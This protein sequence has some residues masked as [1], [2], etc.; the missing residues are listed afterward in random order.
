MSTTCCKAVVAF[1]LPGTGSVHSNCNY[2]AHCVLTYRT[3]MNVAFHYRYREHEKHG[4]SKTAYKLGTF[5]TT[6]QPL[7]ASGEVIVNGK[8]HP[9]AQR[10]DGFTKG[11]STILDDSNRVCFLGD[12][13]A[14]RSMKQTPH[15][16]PKL[17][18]HFSVHRNGLLVNVIKHSS[19]VRTYSVRLLSRVLSTVFRRGKILGPEHGVDWLTS[20]TP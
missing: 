12:K 1:K 6:K 16:R 14:G 4:I 11:R 20:R 7:H 17:C 9:V 13:V 3:T 18:T 10:S 5:T 2:T 15:L 8:K 19:N